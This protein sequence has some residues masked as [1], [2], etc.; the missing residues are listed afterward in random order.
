MEL[1]N[2]SFINEQLKYDKIL[3]ERVVKGRIYNTGIPDDDEPEEKPIPKKIPKKFTNVKKGSHGWKSSA[4]FNI[5][6]I[7]SILPYRETHISCRNA[8]HVTQLC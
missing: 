8:L 7:T 6:D 3:K 5:I 1:K 4:V 2:K